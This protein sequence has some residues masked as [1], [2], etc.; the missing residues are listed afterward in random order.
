MTFSR[1]WLTEAVSAYKWLA[2]SLA[3]GQHLVP[4]IFINQPTRFLCTSGKPGINTHTYTFTVPYTLECVNS[5]FCLLLPLSNTHIHKP[6]GYDRAT[7]THWVFPLLFYCL[8]VM[9]NQSAAYPCC[10]VLPSSLKLERESPLRSQPTTKRLPETLVSQPANQPHTH[11]L[12]H[13]H[14]LGSTVCLVCW[15]SMAL[16]IWHTKLKR[17][18][19]RW[20]EPGEQ[21]SVIMSVTYYL[22]CALYSQSVRAPVCSN[23]GCV[24]V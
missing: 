8:S 5:I 2:L 20:G 14:T 10:A 18:A 4:F 9:C 13:T 19:A 3:I 24:L 11:S 7:H 16:A 21:A 23:F 15:D 17:Q 22:L 6:L 12:T 1:G